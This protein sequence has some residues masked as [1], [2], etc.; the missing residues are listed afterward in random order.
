LYESKAMIANRIAIDLAPGA[1]SQLIKP[2]RRQTPRTT[3][4]GI[5][6]IHLEPDN[7]GIVL[8][9]S[10]GGLGFHAAA[11]VHQTEKIHVGFSLPSNY[12]IE[13]ASELAWA[14]ETRKTGGLRFTVLPAGAREQIRN[15]VAQSTMP[16]TASGTSASSPPLSNEAPTFSQSQPDASPARASD[17]S[18]L[19]NVPNGVR[20]FVS[21]NS[22][23]FFRGF[24]AGAFFSFLVV[25]A[26]F[27][28]T[29]PGQVG[30]PLIQL[31]E[32]LKARSQP[33]VAPL[34]VPG[35][36]NGAAPADGSGTQGTSSEAAPTTGLD[37]P[38]PIVSDSS[39]AQVVDIATGES[40]LAAALRYLRE[41]NGTTDSAAAAQMLWKAVEKGSPAAEVILA[42]LYVRGDG[43]TKNCEQARVL[44]TAASQRGNAEATKKLEEFSTNE[45]L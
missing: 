4:E 25:A 24:A 6:Y 37:R 10:E 7:G 19:P 30:A 28:Y 20:V 22:I 11:P 1:M 35:S 33:T 36:S 23:P 31:G 39:K 38:G 27:L 41:T 34:S 8:N 42:D 44:L 32:R 17:G 9:V 2:E 29:N 43:V 3:V 14:D 26:F 21:W 18:P 5:T 13:A 45:C 12:R 16:V 40:E 15:W